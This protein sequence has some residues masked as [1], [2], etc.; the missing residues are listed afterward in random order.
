[1]D[2]REAYVALNMMEDVGPVTVRSLVS[3]LG[4]AQAIF[5][6]DKQELFNV[7]GPGRGIV[8]KIVAR[9]GEIRVDQ[10]LKRT[11]KLGAHVITPVDDAYPGPLLHIHDPPLALYVLGELEPG[12]KRSVAVVGSRHATYY[13]RES[14][15]RLSYQLALAGFVVI[16][17]LARGIDTAAHRGAL[18]GKGRT[19]AVLGGALD[20]FYPPENTALAKEIAEHGAVLSEFPMGREP[21]KTTFPMRNRII[22]GLCMGVLV[23]EAGS[24]SGALITANQ[25]LDQGRSVFAVPGRIDSPSSRGTHQLIR[26]GARLV[27]SV[28]DILN[29]FEY[30]IPPESVKTSSQLTVDPGSAETRA[31]YPRLLPE[32][33]SV[34]QALED[35]EMDVDTLIRLTGLKAATM[36]SLILG[37]EMKRMVRMLPG[38]LV[39]LIRRG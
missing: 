11:E 15:E 16:S 31:T 2:E 8:E 22:S 10:E 17:G 9:R 20:C 21:D 30:L 6:I 18:K 24:T 36:S 33:E 4:S 39:E 13:G 19:I 28:E 12:D 23:V 1:M 7:Q 26:D 29:E 14:A 32:E 3:A 38:R 5:Q 37:L 27:E 34:V 35:G 25:A